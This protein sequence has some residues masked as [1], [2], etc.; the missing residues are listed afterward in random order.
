MTPKFFAKKSK[1][2]NKPSYVGNLRF[3]SKKEAHRYIDL[4]LALKSGSIQDLKL[5]PEYL[6][7]PAFDK[8][9]KHYRAIHYIADFVYVQN[10]KK[11]VEDVK[12]YRK[13]EL[14][15][16]KWKMFEYTHPELSLRLI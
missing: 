11:V 2:L 16:L 13:K 15:L 3:D 4:S 12:G 5:Q 14:F 6:L 7:Q 8:N 10:G 1:F 9:G